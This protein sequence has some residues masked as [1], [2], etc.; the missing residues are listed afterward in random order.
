MTFGNGRDTFS[1]VQVTPV[2]LPGTQKA[3]YLAWINNRPIYF[4]Y[5]IIITDHLSDNKTSLALVV[6][7][8][9]N[10]RSAAQA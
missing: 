1:G 10:L 6:V 3:G 7:L 2:C 9:G 8:T 4:G 5:K